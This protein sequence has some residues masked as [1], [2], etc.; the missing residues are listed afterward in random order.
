MKK[1]WL[2][3]IAGV[4]ATTLLAG[5][6]IAQD[7][8]AAMSFVVLRDYNGKP[9]RNASVVLHPVKKN[10]K[11]AE[12]GLELKADADGKCSYDGIPYGLVRVQVL[13]RASRLSGRTT[14]L[15]SRRWRLRSS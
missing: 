11:Q 9:I 14:T 5:F 2:G 1:A 7:D 3:L 12:G 6:A 4:L 10:G 13:A 15:I 8:E